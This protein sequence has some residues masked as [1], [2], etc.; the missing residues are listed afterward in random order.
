MLQRLRFRKGRDGSRS[1]TWRSFGCAVFAAAVLVSCT[2]T[3]QVTPAAHTSV[4]TFP[5][6]PSF[7]AAPQPSPT[8][9]PVGTLP[10]GPVPKGFVPASVTFV[11]LN[12]GWVLGSAPCQLATCL[13][14]LKTLNAGRTWVGVNA[15][16]TSFSDGDS[17]D[18]ASV[19]QIRFADTDDGWAYAPGLWSTHDGGAHWHEDSLPSTA[20]PGFINDVEAARGIVDV[21]LFDDNFDARIVTSPVGTDA[22]HETPIAVSGG[23]GAAPSAAI[24]LSGSEG[25]MVEVNRTV[26]GGAR[27]GK[28]GWL[29][30][31]P[32]CGT[33]GGGLLL[34]AATATNLAAVCS[35]GEWTNLPPRVV[36]AFSSNSGSTFSPAALQPGLVQA[37]NAASPAPGA[38]VIATGA[39]QNVVFTATY[40]TGATWEKVFAST[41]DDYT[42][43]IGFTSASQ[44]VAILDDDGGTTATLMMTFNGGRSWAP[45][46]FRHAS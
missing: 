39:G 3:S 29:P 1:V 6:L 25:W 18:M 31:Q 8:P 34:A 20:A 43:F 21:A 37:V 38:V 23:A 19:N 22:W 41:T 2:S 36:V 13:V 35:D 44:G 42:A 10:V 27:F 28:V 40:N 14:L 46:P 32:P 11:S 30:W 4:P 16:P 33:G 24:T 26:L 9:A 15:P 7:G 5:P 17:E 12:E 45:V